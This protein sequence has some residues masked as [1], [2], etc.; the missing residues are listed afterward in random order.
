MA[1]MINGKCHE[2]ISGGKKVACNSPGNQKVYWHWYWG[3]WSP[4]ELAQAE[5]NYYNRAHMN[6][7]RTFYNRLQYYIKDM[8]TLKNGLFLFLSWK[9]VGGRMQVCTP[10]MKNRA[11]LP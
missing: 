6:E 5:M 4:H 2:Y 3:Q 11:Q 10:S 1:I 7:F 9:N 8:L